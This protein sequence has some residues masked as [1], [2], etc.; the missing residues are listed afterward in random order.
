M[1]IDYNILWIE[2]DNSWFETTSEIFKENLEEYGFNLNVNRK[3]NLIEVDAEIKSN[4]L[5]KTDILL[6]DFNLRNS[7]NGDVIINLLRNNEIYTDIIFYSSDLNSVKESMHRYFMEGVYY[8][9]RKEIEHKFNL[10]FKTTIKKIEEINSM[11]GL[12]VGETSELDVCVEKL[13]LLFINDILKLEKKD[14]D[15]FIKEY[16][17]KTI[18]SSIAIFE[19][20][21]TIGINDF[22][23]QIE[24]TKKIDLFRFLLKK[25][26]NINGSVFTDFLELNKS[27]HLDVIDVRNKFAHAKS[28]I[29]EDGKEVLLAQLGKEDFEFDEV[30]FI[31][32]RKNI[33]VHR[34]EMNKLM[35]HFG[36]S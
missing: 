31:Q 17:E 2:D 4:G 13:S 19:R 32:I 25:V 35:V 11:R 21:E 26:N 7:D 6:I 29:K 27:Y 30:K 33:K 24:V 34:E 23:P 9:D 10:V 12:V 8:S 16:S 20:Y 22:F 28:F 15:K 36:I 5:K 3:I 18:K 1:K 14:I